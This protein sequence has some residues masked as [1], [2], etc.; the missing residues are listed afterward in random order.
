MYN[1]LYPYLLKLSILAKKNTIKLRTSSR[2]RNSHQSSRYFI[3]R[4]LVFHTY[5]NYNYN[6]NSYGMVH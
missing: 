4:L 2:T 5:F 1:I 3:D 6:C